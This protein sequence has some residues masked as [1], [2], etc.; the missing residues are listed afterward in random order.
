VIA[1]AVVVSAMVGA[2]AWTL[3]P[4][5][6]L[7]VTRFALALGEGQQFMVQSNQNLAVSPDGTLLVYVANNQLY[8]RSMS[9]LEARPIPGTQ[10]TF[11]LVNPVFSPDS[12]SIAFYAPSDRTIK[13]IA[14]SGGAAATICPAGPVFY[15]M[16][17]DSCGIVFG[18]G[19]QGIMRVSANGGQPTVLVSVKDGELADRPQVLPGGE[20]VLFTIATAA[21]RDAWDK[22]QIVVQSLKSGE[23]KTL[24]SG[25][26]DGLPMTSLG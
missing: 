16:N 12:R 14:V 3:K 2:A 15:G 26:A 13:K 8:L 10:Q 20:W 11:G 7:T 19:S 1:T 5:P 9:D 21:T 17:W 25:G 23:R 24:V 18:R 6:P 22:A 4:T